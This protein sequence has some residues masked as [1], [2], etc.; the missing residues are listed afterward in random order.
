MKLVIFL[1]ALVLD[2]VIGEPP[3]LVHPVVWFGK[4]IEFFDEHY[5]RRSPVLDF[6]VGSSGTI[7]VIGFAFFLSKLL[8]FLPKWFA[9]AVSVYLL[10]SSFAIKSLAR[11]VKDTI[12]EDIEEQRKY[13]GL[14]VSRDVKSL[15]RPH[16][17]SATIESL[18]E[19][20]VDSIV[21]P[22]F[23]YL[24]FGLSGAL[25]YRA[26]NTLDAMIGYRNERY[27]FFGKFAARL[28]DIANFI[29][30]RL[31]VLLFLPLG[32]RK[33]LSHYKK[34]K[35]KING[36]KPIAAMSAVLGVWLEKEGV[37]RFDG[38]TPELGD[39]KQAL[40]VYWIVVVEWILISGLVMWRW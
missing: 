17:N 14:I 20:T 32:P 2:L 24:I 4:L 11:H 6:A 12:R 36:D 5:K 13:V 28:D 38:R 27:E 22:L 1:L 25:I 3:A 40:R 29:P 33:V 8:Y 26:V 16:L 10:K 31:T 21:A 7:I 30:A 19:N 9:I 34:A 39:I 37:Y 35:F 18:A 23:Y 15:D